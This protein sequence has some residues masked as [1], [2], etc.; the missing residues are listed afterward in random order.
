[1]ARA[2]RCTIQKPANNSEGVGLWEWQLFEAEKEDDTD[3]KAAQAVTD[4]IDALGEITLE[5]EADVA[6]ARA[7]YDELTDAQ[8]ALVTE[9]TLKKLTGCRGNN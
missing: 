9:E 6:A 8:K 3:A 7:A 1:M 2:L 4:M 5:K